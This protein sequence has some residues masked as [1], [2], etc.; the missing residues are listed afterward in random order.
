VVEHHD[1]V[2][3][4]MRSVASK[5]KLEELFGQKPKIEYPRLPYKANLITVEAEHKHG[6]VWLQF[7]PHEGWAQLRV[8][9]KPF[10][11][12]KLDLLDI[13]HMNVRKQDGHPVLVFRFARALTSDLKLLLKPNVMLF[14]GNEG[15]GTKAQRQ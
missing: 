15:P 9:A 12:V 1:D 4:T 14:W 3:C 10:S 5:E 13:S 8:V 2:D 7:M 6:S 11:I